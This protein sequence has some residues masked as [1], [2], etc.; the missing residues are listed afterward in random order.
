MK[1]TK[2]QRA[3]LGRKENIGLQMPGSVSWTQKCKGHCG[4]LFPP[5]SPRISGKKDGLPQGQRE[6]RR[7]WK[8][9]EEKREMKVEEAVVKRE[10]V[11]VKK[12]KVKRK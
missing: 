9:G 3:I 5:L 7:N 1:N 11:K 8:E 10:K 12:E 2:V 4:D 6:P